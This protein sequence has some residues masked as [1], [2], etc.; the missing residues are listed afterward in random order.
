MPFSG[1]LS[2]EGSI[3]GIPGGGS[4]IGPTTPFSLVNFM[5]STFGRPSKIPAKKLARYRII[6]SGQLSVLK[7]AG[8]QNTG[9]YQQL[10]ASMQSGTLNKSL[11]VSTQNLI[12]PVSKSAIQAA[13]QAQQASQKAGKSRKI[14]WWID[15]ELEAIRNSYFKPV[16]VGQKLVYKNPRTQRGGRKQVDDIQLRFRPDLV[17]VNVNKVR[18]SVNAVP[19]ETTTPT[20]PTTP[21]TPT[22][23]T[24]PTT[25]TI[26]PGGTGGITGTGTTGTTGTGT[27]QPVQPKKKLPSLPISQLLKLIPRQTFTPEDFSLP[28]LPPLPNFNFNAA[29]SVLGGSAVSSP[30][31]FTTLASQQQPNQLGFGLGQPFSP[32]G[33]SLFSSKRKPL[34]G[35]AFLS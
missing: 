25:P 32:T 14:P 10:Q 6:A 28:P 23:P 35:L 16:T 2:N 21:T 24:T 13:S 33:G 20:I 1:L 18:R 30:F 34:G 11:L 29:N 15:P 26:P 22:I 8:L 5:A 9:L 12:S 31:N 27:S 3:P 4:L 17:S 19:G 7:R